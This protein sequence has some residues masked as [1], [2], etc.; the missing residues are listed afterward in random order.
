[1]A[2]R[3]DTQKLWC[4]IRLETRLETVLR[5]DYVQN[6]QIMTNNEKQ[7]F[8]SFK[9]ISAFLSWVARQLLNYI[10][11]FYSLREKATK[12][13]SKCTGKV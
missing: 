8:C 13:I 7:R 6:N 3:A 5:T 10:A 1:M 12:W 11:F 2:G 4:K 9:K